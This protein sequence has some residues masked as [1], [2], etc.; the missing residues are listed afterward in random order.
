MTAVQQIQKA[1]QLVGNFA[2]GE[3][4]RFLAGTDVRQG[5]TA[6]LRWQA[7]E[8]FAA[9]Q[10]RNALSL[11]ERLLEDNAAPVRMSA[12]LALAQLSEPKALDSLVRAFA[13]D[14]GTENG[15]SR[16]PEVRAA[17]L[18]A[19]WLRDAKASATREMAR[20]ATA[21]PDGAVRFI[22]WAMLRPAA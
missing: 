18:R 20:L 9:A 15:V 16:S 3:R 7:A 5:A 6:Q 13:L 12:A 4:S 19:A 2:A 8:A 17:L 1:V 10:P 22:G 21:D 11:L 14:F